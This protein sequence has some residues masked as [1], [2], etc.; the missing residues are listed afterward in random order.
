MSVLETI[1]AIR[2]GL[3]W[4]GLWTLGLCLVALLACAISEKRH[5]CR[6]PWSRQARPSPE[7][8]GESAASPRP[9]RSVLVGI[10]LLAI[11]CTLFGGGKMRSGG[12]RGATALPVFQSAHAGFWFT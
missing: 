5:F 10:A 4:I 8:S 11:V 9:S 3:M 1:E 12:G 2:S 7:E 6:F